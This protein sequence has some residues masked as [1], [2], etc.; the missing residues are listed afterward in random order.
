MSEQKLCCYWSFLTGENLVKYF[1]GPI[2]FG[3]GVFCV[4]PAACPVGPKPVPNP[5]LGGGP[6]TSGQPRL[7]VPTGPEAHQRSV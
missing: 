6:E 5:G 4:P 3:W 2:F 1:F 7:S